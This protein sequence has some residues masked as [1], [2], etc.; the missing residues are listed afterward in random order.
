[1]F[2]Y[3]IY[4]AYTVYIV[5]IQY[6]LFIYSIYCAY[7]VYI[8]YIQYILCIHSIYCLYIV[9]IKYIL[10]IVISYKHL[11]MFL[12]LEEPNCRNI[13]PVLCDPMQDTVRDSAGCCVMGD[14]QSCSLIFY[15]AV[16]FLQVT[17]YY[18]LHK[19]LCNFFVWIICVCTMDSGFCVIYAIVIN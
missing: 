1:M 7:T 4:C 10:Y 8:V 6:M 16:W 12:G 9:H 13:D 2:I 11:E 14:R 17:L 3:S 18:L 19:T 5:Y 15:M